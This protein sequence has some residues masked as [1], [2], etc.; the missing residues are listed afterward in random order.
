MH[1]PALREAVLRERD[2]AHADEAAK[3]MHGLDTEAY[4]PLATL[5]LDFT[6]ATGNPTEYRRT[7]SLDQ[8]VHAATYRLTAFASDTTPFSPRQP[9]SWSCG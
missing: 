5:H 7:L 9:V 4:Q 3:R 2:Y 1:L 8:A 6:D